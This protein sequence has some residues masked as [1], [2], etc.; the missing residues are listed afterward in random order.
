MLTVKYLVRSLNLADFFDC[1]V[2][3]VAKKIDENI[4]ICLCL[5]QYKVIGVLFVLRS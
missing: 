3:V 2:L 1:T 4:I 5:R